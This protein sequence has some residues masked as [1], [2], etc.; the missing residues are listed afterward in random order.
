MLVRLLGYLHSLSL[1]NPLLRTRHQRQ[2]S[3]QADPG[4]QPETLLGG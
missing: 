4:P 2:R 1:A 3:S